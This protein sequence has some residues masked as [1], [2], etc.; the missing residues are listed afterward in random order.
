MATTDATLRQFFTS[1]KFAV[2]GASTNTEKFGYKGT[3]SLDVL[4]FNLDPKSHTT[5]A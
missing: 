5:S 1:P 4:G 3:P 2:V